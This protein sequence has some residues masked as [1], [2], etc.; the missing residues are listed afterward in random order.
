MTEFFLVITILGCFSFFAKF[1]SIIERFQ[2]PISLI[3]SSFV[4][5]LFTLFD[6]LKSSTIFSTWKSWPSELIAIIFASLFLEKSENSSQSTFNEIVNEGILVWLSVLGQTII[7]ISLT[8]FVFQKFYEI[9][10]SFA[11]ILET[12]FAGGHGTA[13]AMKEIL[14]KNGLKGGLEFGLFS[15]T[16]GMILGI[17][18]GIFII[19]KEGKKI[20]ENS[21]VSEKFSISYFSLIFSGT[22]IFIAYFIGKL[23]QATFQ[24]YSTPIP[25]LPLFVYALFG[26]ILLKFLLK[27]SKQEYLLDNSSNS[28]IASIVMEILIFTG[29][30]TMNLQIILKFLIPLLI[31]FGFGFLWNLFCH[32]VL[33]KKLIHNNYRFELSLIN[34]GMLNGTTATGLMLWKMTDPSMKSKAGK[35]YAA[36]S[37]FS[38][39]LIGGGILTLSYPFLLTNFNPNLILFILISVWFSLFFFGKHLLKKIQKF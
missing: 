7:A 4:L 38:A 17:V 30:S 15:A 18:G 8:L 2:I 31:L 1:F 16:A 14:E 27:I 28:L 36:A 21:I 5:I 26:S 22:L 9:P 25:V 6:D 3:S 20:R 34:F 32:F 13:F 39:P 37:P 29:I 23:L 24:S 33:S 10:M 11:I 12:G 19:I 35:I